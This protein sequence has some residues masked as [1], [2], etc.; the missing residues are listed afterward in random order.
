MTPYP[1]MKSR[2]IIYSVRDVEDAVPY[3]NSLAHRER[4]MPDGMISGRMTK[5]PR[6]LGEGRVRVIISYNNH[7]LTGR[8]GRRPLRKFP[9]PSGE[10]RVRVI[11][12]DLNH[13][14]TGQRPQKNGTHCV[15]PYPTMKSR[16]IIYS[17]R[18]VEDAV[19]YVNSLA[20]W[21]RVGSG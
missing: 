6:P 21:E 9:R 15:T 16:F 17:L 4:A 5:F 14:F 12:A 3:E 10:G 19:P 7:A 20:R 13:T 1:T 18:D 8:R 11:F 2:C